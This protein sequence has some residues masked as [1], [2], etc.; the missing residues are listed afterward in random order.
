MEFFS[1]FKRKQS[2]EASNLHG[3]DI[4]NISC[5]SCHLKVGLQNVDSSWKCFMTA[6]TK[7]RNSSIQQDGSNQRCIGNTSQTF[8]ATLKA[9]YKKRVYVS[10]LYEE[11]NKA[12][13]LKKHFW[14]LKTAGQRGIRSHITTQNVRRSVKGYKLIQLQSFLIFHLT[15]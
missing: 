10:I 15:C 11:S 2:K 9:P 5:R 13:M 7:Q 4:N 14:K 8:D 6:T 12:F 1:S 3:K